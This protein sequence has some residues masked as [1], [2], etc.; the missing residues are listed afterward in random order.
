MIEESK[1]QPYM[2]W[3]SENYIQIE[4]EDRKRYKKYESSKDKFDEQI[5]QEFC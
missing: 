2:H 1:A 5:C 4:N 3:I